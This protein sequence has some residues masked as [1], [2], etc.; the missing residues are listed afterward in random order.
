MKHALREKSRVVTI[1]SIYKVLIPILLLAFFLGLYATN[2]MTIHQDEYTVYSKDMRHESL[3]QI[4]TLGSNPASHHL[5]AIFL[6][7]GSID[8]WGD[9][10]F[11]LRWPSILT[12]VMSIALTYK[13][14]SWLFDKKVGIGAA[15]LLIFNPYAMYYGHD[16]RGYMA[17]MFYVLA[18]Y[19]L[20]ICA[21]QST[22][23]R[24]WI[25]VGAVMSA[26][27]YNHLYAA[28]AWPGLFWIVFIY[29]RH[30]RQWSIRL[31]GQAI[32]TMIFSLIGALILYSPL[33]WHAAA[34]NDVAV[35]MQNPSAAP[36]P[37]ATLSWFNGVDLEGFNRNHPAVV[38]LLITLAVITCLFIV[39]SRRS[40]YRAYYLI[41]WFFLPLMI[42]HFGNWFVLPSILARPRYFSFVLPYYVLFLA[43]LPFELTKFTKRFVPGQWGASIG[44][45]I[46]PAIVAFWI[47]PLSEMYTRETTGNWLA[48]SDYIISHRQS[49]DI[50]LCESFEHQWWK[51]SYHDQNRNC[52]LSI[53]YWLNTHHQNL[54]YPVTNFGEISAYDQIASIDPND[55]AR[56]RRA[57]VVVWGIPQD[58][59]LGNRALPE[60]DRFGRTIVLPPSPA[61][62]AVEALMSHIEQLDRLS[63]DPA[64]HLIHHA[65]LAQLADIQGQTK[66]VA[67]ELNY[68]ETLQEKLQTI[69]PELEQYLEV[70][71]RALEHQPLLSR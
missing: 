63:T 3:W 68:V 55:L 25:A 11:S 40:N 35:E 29:S 37:I 53:Q 8:I 22:Q 26:A 65:R 13:I 34:E 12:S 49:S 62:N 20:A 16:S 71:K 45:L 47:P 31:W 32:L 39:F 43:A 14:G 17:M 70:E 38:Y 64:I 61:S 7:K 58:I 56:V 10:L 19:Y 27:V 66:R 59:N 23:K 2:E 1:M 36:S 46:V 5:L 57:W 52:R 24:Y 51:S 41:G 67:E 28:L 44:Y 21:I 60:W 4:L 42:Y 54:L 33:I 48:V 6:A 30:K 69:S 50:I 9:T 15:L 18:A